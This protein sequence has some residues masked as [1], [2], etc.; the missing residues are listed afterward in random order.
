MAEGFFKKYAPEGFK[1][2]SAGTKPVSQI[3][4]IVVEAMREVGIDISNQKSKE[5][6]EEMIR[7]SEHI[8]NM[9]CMDKNFCPT[10]FLPKVIE[11]NLPDPKGKSIED[12]RKIR[13]EIEKRIKELVTEITDAIQK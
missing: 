2:Q 11:W 4:R 7:D 1:V 10:I 8:V 12:V 5:M 9:G 13:D 3:N 6:T